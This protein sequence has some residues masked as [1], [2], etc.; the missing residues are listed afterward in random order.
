MKNLRLTL[1][2]IIVLISLFPL[3]SY[4]KTGYV[5]D[6]LI[7]TFREGPGKSYRV[8]KRLKSDTPVVILREKNGFYKVRLKPGEIGWVDK[9]FI[10]FTL[11]KSLIIKQVKAENT[12]LRD[13][14]DKLRSTTRDL[15]D[16]VSSMEQ[17]FD[18]AK[19]KLAI[20]SKKPMVEQTKAVNTL[21]D[22]QD[23]DNILVKYNALVEQTGN[24]QNII[25]ENNQLKKQNKI[26]SE[27]LSIIKKKKQT[28]F[29]TTMIKWFFTGAAVL[30]IGWIMGQSVFSKKQHSSSLLR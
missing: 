11:P 15:N 18:Q 28:I 25:K 17:D 30:F 9:D 21:S 3:S 19:Q 7:L 8:T 14:M 1:L 2:I 20:S 13:Q 10:V 16:K 24:I 12:K 26:L 4:A 22:S 23:E 29:K 5:S 6:M 27:K